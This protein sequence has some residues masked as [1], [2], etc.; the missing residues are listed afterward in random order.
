MSNNQENQIITNNNQNE[1]NFTTPVHNNEN[2]SD[3]LSKPENLEEIKNEQANVEEEY[4]PFTNPF[5][6]LTQ[7]E[8][9]F[10]PAI[11]NINLNE[12]KNAPW[13]KEGAKLD[14]YFNYGYNEEQW[15]NYSE[16]IKSKFD[17]LV[18]LVKN[19]KKK[20]PNSKNELNY[21]MEFPSDFGGL[22]E[23]YDDQQY[24]EVNLF[25]NKTPIDKLIPQMRYTPNQIYVNL[26][27]RPKK[28]E[29]PPP[30]KNIYNPN[31]KYITTNSRFIK[32]SQP[33]FFNF[34]NPYTYNP[35]Y[36]SFPQNFVR[37]PQN[38]QNT[39]FNNIPN[40][41]ILVNNNINNN[42]NTIPQ[43]NDLDNEN[44]KDDKNDKNSEE[45]NSE[46]YSKKESEK[47][48]HHKKDNDKK[49]ERERESSRKKRDRSRE[50]SKND[51][52]KERERERKREKERKRNEKNREKDRNREKER[53]RDFDR[54]RNNYKYYDKNYK[55]K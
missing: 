47:K 48:H 55:R 52:Y 1:T 21:L 42:N 53:Y 43:K 17:E 16:K 29:S 24:E 13:K 19:G 36:Y 12:I 30:N 39:F 50:R 31:I 8:N 10:V 9:I 23:V 22:G 34:P 32:P 45:H 26:E 46:K 4:E 54:K 33:T 40:N 25:D 5:P 28:P 51:R 2:N 41:N 14:D 11:F 15:I 18:N 49:R 7:Y 27:E 44:N 38:P 3:S 35:I 37:N 20:L 6:V